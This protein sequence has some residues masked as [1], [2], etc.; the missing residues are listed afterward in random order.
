MA[1]INGMCVLSPSESWLQDVLLAGGERAG[2]M[3]LPQ[4]RVRGCEKSDAVWW[5]RRRPSCS[6]LFVHPPR[7]LL[8]VRARLPRSRG[9]RCERFP[10]AFSSSR[11]GFIMPL[12]CS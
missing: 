4:K 3:P 6:W 5:A 11:A 9:R 1:V 2:H 12:L 7:L 10:K 8:W